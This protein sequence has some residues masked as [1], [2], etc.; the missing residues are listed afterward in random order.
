MW[1]PPERWSFQAGKLPEEDVQVHFRPELHVRTLVGLFLL[2]SLGVPCLGFPIKSLYALQK[3]RKS[4]FLEAR[5]GRFPK[6]RCIFLVVRPHNKDHNILGSVLGSPFFGKVPN[7][8]LGLVRAKLGNWHPF[9]EIAA[10]V[11]SNNQ[12][13]SAL[14]KTRHVLNP[15][16]H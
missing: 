1:K 5:H 14:H 13:P 16:R 10:Q 4:R 11:A 9:G 8:L 3:T 12:A 15:T 7:S 6:I 2:Y